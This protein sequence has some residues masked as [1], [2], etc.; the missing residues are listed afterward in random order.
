MY[1]NV[2]KTTATTSKSSAM[3]AETIKNAVSPKNQR[4]RGNIMI[5]GE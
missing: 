5:I 2:T 1:Q 4:S 3:E